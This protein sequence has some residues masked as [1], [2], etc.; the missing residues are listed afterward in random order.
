MSVRAS[1]S[2]DDWF[3]IAY[4]NT[5]IV[6]VRDSFLRSLNSLLNSFQYNDC[7]GSSSRRNY[8]WDVAS[9]FQYNDCVGSRKMKRI[10]TTDKQHFNTTIVSVRVHFEMGSILKSRLFQYNDCVG[11][12]DPSLADSI[13][14]FKFQ[15]NDCVGSSSRRNYPWDVASW[16]QY[17]DCVGSSLLS[18]SLFILLLISIQ[19]LCRFESNLF[20]SA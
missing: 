3:L 16:F 8:P 9:W 14:T 11:S 20:A 17:N 6:S 15:Y 4:F 2:A 1:V 5:T 13:K 7:V 18:S 10:L 19:R 12:R